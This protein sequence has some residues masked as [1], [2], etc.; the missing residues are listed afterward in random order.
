LIIRKKKLVFVHV[1]KT[2][3]SSIDSALKSA[4]RVPIGK[5]IQTCREIHGLLGEKSYLKFFK[6]AVVRNPWDRFLSK[7]LWSQQH[8]GSISPDRTFRWYVDHIPKIRKREMRKRYDA[9]S[10]QSE[11]LKDKSGEIRISKIIR[12]ESL[13]AGWAEICDLIGLKRCELPHEKVTLHNH[14]SEY[15][16]D[17][18]RQVIGDLYAEDIERFGYSFQ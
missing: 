3:G 16:D 7:F 18:S 10:S 12:F 5:R 13:A 11:W 9:F 14:Y 1:P 8:T 2:G 15:Y 17:H 4:F 6:F